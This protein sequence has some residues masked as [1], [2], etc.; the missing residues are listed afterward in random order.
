[1]D[2]VNTAWTGLANGF[3]SAQQAL[4]EG[5]VQPALFATGLAGFLVLAAKCKVFIATST[6]PNVGSQ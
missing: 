4:F 5:V 3:D 1:M 6:R 2:S